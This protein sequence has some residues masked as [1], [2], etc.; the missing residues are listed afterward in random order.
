M[1]TGEQR[2]STIVA[3]ETTIYA[4]GNHV[5]GEAY[6]GQTVRWHARWRQ[7]RTALRAGVHTNPALQAAND[8]DG[9]G[10]FGVV[11]LDRVASLD[12]RYPGLIWRN[13]IERVWCARARAAGVVLYN[14][15]VGKC[16]RRAA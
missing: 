15:Q 3:Y 9:L 13:R 11:I 8:Q 5:T 14:D 12:G 2:D 10:A 16:R 7:H 1:T 4:I 6:I